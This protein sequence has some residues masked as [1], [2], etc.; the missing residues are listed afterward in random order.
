MRSALPGGLVRGQDPLPVCPAL[1]G[2][3]FPARVTQ[4]RACSADGGQVEP[5]PRNSLTRQAIDAHGGKHD[6]KN[7]TTYTPPGAPRFLKQILEYNI[8]AEVCKS[9]E[10]GWTDFHKSSSPMAAAAPLKPLRVPAGH[11]SPPGGQLAARARSQKRDRTLH[12]SLGL[13]LRAQRLV[14]GARPHHEV[15]WVILAAVWDPL[16]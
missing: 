11:P 2:H 15:R 6:V 3:I 5:Q 7:R 8:H 9:Q 10:R 1:R 16:V 13:D 12:S 4:H 14:P